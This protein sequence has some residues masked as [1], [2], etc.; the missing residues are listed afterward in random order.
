MKYAQSVSAMAIAAVSLLVAPPI[1]DA[2]AQSAM[3]TDQAAQS[4][5]GRP[6]SCA[7]KDMVRPFPQLAP[8]F[9]FGGH[10][11]GPPHFAAHLSEMETE[12]GIRA[13]QLD[14]WRDFTDALIAIAGPPP[15][16]VADG[17]KK[18]EAFA[19]AVQ[20]AD[21]AV[22]RGQKA[23]ALKKAVGVLR[24]KLSA[25][26]LKKAAIIEERLAGRFPLPPPP[27]P[28]HPMGFGDGS[29]YAPSSLGP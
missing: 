27:P 24:E 5:E 14:S 12:I 17:N 18:A 13:D 26:Q 4:S 21:T 10:P 15:R 19:M 16:P 6:G 23:E 11:P 8:P 28:P 1:H 29:P 22:E 20:M 9:G 25:E 7:P 3:P 2:I